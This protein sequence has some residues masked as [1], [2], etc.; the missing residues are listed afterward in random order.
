MVRL[1]DARHSC[2]TI[3]LDAGVQMTVVQRPLGHASMT[4]TADTYTRRT[5][6]GRAP[7]GSAP[8]QVGANP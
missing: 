8:A 3:L 4:L 7:C 5:A 6:G 2:A 1:Y